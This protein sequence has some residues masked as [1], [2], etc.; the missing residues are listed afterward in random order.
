ML[1]IWGTKVNRD[2]RGTV[3]DQCPACME[4]QR[5]AVTDHYEVS[6]IYY[7]SVGQG[8]RVASTRQCWRCGS[9]FSCVRDG[10]NEFLGEGTAKGMSLDEIIERTNA[11]LAEVRA[12]RRRIETMASERPSQPGGDSATQ[13]MLPGTPLREAPTM[14][15]D[16]DLRE[17]L[18]RLKAY[19]GSAPEVT[20]FLQKL[21]GWR[22]L[23]SSGR[24]ALLEEV[25]TFID[26]QQKTDRAI[27]F[28][29]RMV[30]SYPQH[31]GWFPALVLLAA[32]GAVFWW[33]Y[34]YCHPCVLLTF[35][36][37]GIAAVTACYVYASSAIRRRWMRH[38]VIPQAEEAGVDLKTLAVVMTGLAQLTDRIGE[39]MQEMAAEAWLLEQEALALGRW[40]EEPKTPDG[41]SSNA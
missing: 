19:E 33:A 34:S 7:I 30:A 12:A 35:G 18:G 27:A 13:M 26:N 16:A 1:I 6:H 21:Q 41:P 32:L 11:P 5:F 4:V 10:Y 20:D 25:S 17:T 37:I 23:D 28:L 15:Q 9:E 14:M 36:A 3:A 40:D 22:S 29:D 2:P 24:A 31:V 39:K 8:T 38:T